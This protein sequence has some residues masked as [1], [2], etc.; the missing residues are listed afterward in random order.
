M[1]FSYLPSQ[2]YSNVFLLKLYELL[3]FCSLTMFLRKV[4]SNVLSDSVAS[5]VML[6]LYLYS[7]NTS[8]HIKG[9]NNEVFSFVSQRGHL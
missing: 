1:V 3:L 2:A 5:V 8:Q 7:W 6:L 4:F 9:Y